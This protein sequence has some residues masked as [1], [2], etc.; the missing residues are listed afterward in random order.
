MTEDTASPDSDGAAEKPVDLDEVADRLE[1]ALDRI[2]RQLDAGGPGAVP[3][4]LAARLD[5]L[6]E[7]LRGVLGQSPPAAGSDV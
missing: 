5:R 1:A 2:A 7:R 4:E 3:A 6:I